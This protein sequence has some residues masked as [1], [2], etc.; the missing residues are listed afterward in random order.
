MARLLGLVTFVALSIGF[1]DLTEAQVARRRQN[2]TDSLQTLSPDERAKTRAETA[3][4]EGRHDEAIELTTDVLTRNSR[5]HVALYL[6]ASARIE[7]GLGSR[8]TSL[9]RSGI[10]DARLAIQHGD[11]KP[12]Y[13]LPYL[14]GM[15]NLGI[16]ESRDDHLQVAVETANRAITRETDQIGRA[17]LLYQ[18]GRAYSALKQYDLASSDFAEATRLR[19]RF[20][21][22]YMEHA[23]TLA[24]SG[25]AERAG[26]IFDD[27]VRRFATQP[28][29]FNNRGLHRQKQGQLDGAIA[30]F[31]KAVELNPNYSVAFT[32]RGYVYL[33][34]GDSASAEADFT[35]SLKANPGYSSVYGL[36]GAA[37]LLQGQLDAAIKDYETRLKQDSR[38][39]I[40]HADL[41]FAKCFA[42]DY[43]SAL[44]AFDQAVKRDPTLDFLA[45]WQ[46]LAITATNDVEQAR[47]QFVRLL[48]KAEPDQ[49]WTDSLV[50]FLAGN[51]DA[52]ALIG[53][54]IAAGPDL[55]D[56]RQC[57]AHY[58]IAQSLLEDGQ[59]DEALRHFQLALD[60]GQR[61][62]SAYRGAVVA[63]RQLQTRRR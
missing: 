22:A 19:P 53:R 17:N 48:E 23:K 21:A 35:R 63:L 33:E 13:Y 57:E 5:D 1:P 34:K 55:T 52:N 60:G 24:G 56:A 36:R 10:E 30:D 15:T 43:A 14:Y 44:A 58:F 12:M 40:A 54:A 59:R 8:D 7:R 39:A 4:R 50:A 45:P 62:L 20:L 29:V 41:G 49:Q 2:P 31:S 28:L 61:S 51:T 27:A 9:I 26:N 37:R 11:A 16:I 38:S 18:R 32:N 25:D 6:R 42:G 3:H 47:T 46:F